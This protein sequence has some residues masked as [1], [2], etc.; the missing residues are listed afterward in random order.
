[1]KRSERLKFRPVV[2]GLEDR[3]L[4]AAPI[5]EFSVPAGARGI[6]AGP[7]GDLWFTLADDQIG[8]ITPD[9]QVAT[10]SIPPSD[11]GPAIITDGPDGNLWFTFDDGPGIGRITPGGQFTAFAAGKSPSDIVAGPDANLWFT[12]GANNAIGRIT[13]TGQITEFPIPTATASPM[14]ITAG[15]DGN[16][17]F[18]EYHSGKIGR[19]TT[20]GAFAEFPI[21]GLPVPVYIA[22][23]ADGNLWFT[24]AW[25]SIYRMTTAGEYTLFPLHPAQNYPIGYTPPNPGL[26]GIAAGPDGN[27]WF[28]ESQTN[29]I[30]RMTPAGVVTEFPVPTENSNPFGI[31]AGSDGNI[32]FAENEGNKIGRFRVTTTDLGVAVTPQP[33]QGVVGQGLTYTIT[34]TNHGPA[35]ATDVVLTEDYLPTSSLTPQP[36]TTFS[37]TA[38]QGNV[39]AAPFLAQLGSLARGASATVTVVMVA[40]GPYAF[41]SRFTVHANESDTNRTNDADTLSVTIG[42]GSSSNSRQ[43]NSPHILSLRPIRVKRKG[44]TAI[45]IGFDGPMNPGRLQNLGIYHLVTQA[46]GKHSRS[47][48]VALISASYDAASRSVRLSLKK[49]V[50]TGKLRLTIDHSGVIAANGLGLSGGDYTAIVPN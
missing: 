27:L 4:L 46:K 48:A 20:D 2:A 39:R 32:W 10:F 30:G 3:R 5:T 22:A 43:S 24:S 31:A 49:P 33:A 23:G 25:G 21:A 34:V 50:K 42:Q 45:V 12:D 40:S 18:T 41:K 7:G 15:P 14:G 28:T 35:E 17:W 44:L 47:K 36:A 29:L 1:M 38:S 9:G 13:P 16:L 11:G 37:A 19:I 26:A 6:A 8:R